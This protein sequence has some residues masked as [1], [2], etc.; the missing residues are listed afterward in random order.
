MVKVG[1]KVRLNVEGLPL[2]LVTNSISIGRWI[3]YFKVYK[4]NGG[5]IT[6]QSLCAG[7]NGSMHAH[8]YPC[9]LYLNTK[10]LVPDQII[11][12]KNKLGNFPRK[13][14]V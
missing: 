6:V 12:N 3:D 5:G 11:L 10:Y 8:L 9:A 14:V 7:E 1:D 2:D 4:S 13:K